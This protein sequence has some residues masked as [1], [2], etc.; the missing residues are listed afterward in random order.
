M[1]PPKTDTSIRTVPINSYCR[2]ALEKQIIQHKIVMSKTCRKNLEFPDL[3]FTTKLGTPLN[4]ELYGA[5]I[6]RIVQEV[7]LMRD[8]LDLMENFSGH[9]FRHTFATRCFEAGIAPK[10]VQAYILL[11][12]PVHP[13]RPLWNP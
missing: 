10:T 7:N 12:L 8:S 6:D 9:C 4:A 11:R 5:A 3:L 2:R 13:I 1:G